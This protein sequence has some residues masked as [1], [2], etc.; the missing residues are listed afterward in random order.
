M[1][2]RTTSEIT[3]STEKTTEKTTVITE[4]TTPLDP[5]LMDMEILSNLNQPKDFDDTDDDI[6]NEIDDEINNEI[7]DEISEYP[8]LLDLQTLLKEELEKLLPQIN[9]ATNRKED[10]KGTVLI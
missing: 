6:N 5:V 9:P 4:K 3:T 7:D 8:G 2:S 10:T 1:Q